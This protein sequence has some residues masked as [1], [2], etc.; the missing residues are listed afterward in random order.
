MFIVIISLE[1]NTIMSRHEIWYVNL[2]EVD[3]W[4][5]ICDKLGTEIQITTET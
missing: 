3:T 4:P 5:G 2:D 1:W